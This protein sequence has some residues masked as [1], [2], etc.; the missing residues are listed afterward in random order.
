MELSVQTE[1][2]FVFFVRHWWSCMLVYVCQLLFVSF[3]L[4]NDFYSVTAQ[5]QLYT[6]TYNAH[7]V[8]AVRV[9]GACKARARARNCSIKRHFFSG[10]LQVARYSRLLNL[11]KWWRWYLSTSNQPIF[12]CSFCSLHF[13]KEDFTDHAIK[14]GGETRVGFTLSLAQA[15]WLFNVCIAGARSVCAVHASDRSLARSLHLCISSRLPCLFLCKRCLETVLILRDL[16]LYRRFVQN[17]GSQSAANFMFTN[18]SERAKL[19]S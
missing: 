8:R 4:V 3:F 19:A 10:V 17:K 12:G 5:M 7:A 14:D 18:T 9:G 11:Q 2:E 6:P 16:R 13:C 15:S 1:F